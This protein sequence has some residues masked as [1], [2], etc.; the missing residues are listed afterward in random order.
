MNN[1]L[2][3]AA[4]AISVIFDSLQLTDMADAA[5][6]RAADAANA[7]GHDVDGGKNGI[8]LLVEEQVIVAEVRT[9]E[10]PVEVLR[11][12]VERERIGDE[13]VDGLHHSL[14]LLRHQVNLICIPLRCL[15]FPCVTREHKKTVF[16]KH[17]R[18]QHFVSQPEALVAAFG[19]NVP[20][21]TH[22]SL[23]SVHL[24]TAHFSGF[25]ALI[26]LR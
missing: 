22:R 13:R 8:G 18:R 25:D 21:S 20:G 12:D 19:K 9:G 7:L 3:S 4:S 23:K 10:V 11:L 16:G 1:I 2:T 5:D 14:R 6:G 17:L 15:L 26:P 24:D